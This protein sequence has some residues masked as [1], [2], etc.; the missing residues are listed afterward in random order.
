[1]GSHE[2][3]IARLTDV[4]GIGIRRTKILLSAVAVIWKPLK[5]VAAFA[6]W[7]KLYH[8]NNETTEKGRTGRTALQKHLYKTL[9]VKIALPA[10]KKKKM[11][12]SIN[13]SYARGRTHCFVLCWALYMAKYLPLC[14]KSS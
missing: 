7:A 8:G 4:L 5:D 6:N 13:L 3:L 14:S 9:M 10:V 2:Q 12:S 1:M 11:Q